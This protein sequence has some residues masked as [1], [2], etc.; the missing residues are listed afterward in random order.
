MKEDK[1][2]N[3]RQQDSN[4]RN[5]ILKEESVRPQMQQDLNARLMQRVAIKQTPRKRGF[6]TSG[7]G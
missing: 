6:A 4:L 3:I 1:L 2:N 5:A 7:H